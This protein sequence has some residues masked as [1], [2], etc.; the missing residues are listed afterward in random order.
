M[1]M[2]YQAVRQRGHTVA[3]GFS[4]LLERVQPLDSEVGA[5]KAHRAT[6]EQGLRAEFANFNRLTVIG[7]HTR[8]SAI[9]V[10]SD[11]DYLAVVGRS[12]VTRGGDL[13][14]S[15]TALGRVRSALQR[16][17]PNTDI[18]LDGP[19]V[20]V[21]FGQ[22]KG[23]VDVVP[24]FWQGTTAIDGYPKFAIPDAMGGWQLTSPQRHG[25]FVEQA[26]QKSGYK[27]NRVAQLLKVWK[28]T[29]SPKIPFLGFHVELLLGHEG[30]CV[31]P[32]GYGNCLFEAFVL[33]A[34]RNGRA[35]NDPLAISPR[36]PIAYTDTQ[37]KTLVNHATFA[38]EHAA[39]ALRAE[40]EGDIN[41]AY[42]QWNLVFKGAFP[43]R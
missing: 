24:G 35:L 12:D 13:V 29:R 18:W 1:N 8:D 19:A 38:A 15:T 5:L 40:T 28:H 16:R 22:G 42:R 10:V 31:G 23:S 33:L 9:Q 41:E 37:C 30:V 43:A 27:L 25:K 20:I 39:R 2:L 4:K 34:N 6:I 32:K 14:T 11:V 17:F 21:G 7:S 26:N 36:I 3:D